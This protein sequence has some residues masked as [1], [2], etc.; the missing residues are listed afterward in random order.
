M[1]NSGEL[2][3]LDHSRKKVN[4]LNTLLQN[5]GYTC[6]KALYADAASCVLPLDPPAST[7]SSADNPKQAPSVAAS[8]NQEVE[9]GSKHAVD[10]STQKKKSNVET[11][12]VDVGTAKRVDRKAR[13]AAARAKGKIDK[14]SAMKLATATAAASSEPSKSAAYDKSAKC[15]GFD[16]E[17][18]DSVL[19][20]PP[21]SA[22]GL[23]PRLRVDLSVSDVEE[24]VAAQRRIFWA[25]VM[26][27]K[28]GGCLVF[29][30]C[31]VGVRPFCPACL[32]PYCFQDLI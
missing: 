30:T 11:P 12:G 24:M 15:L 27:L 16:A 8:A 31:T 10:S 20:D 23:R 26:L 19:L 6:A 17:S 5:L 25:A 7:T 32:F 14:H 18:F 29:S 28:P 13:V 4:E 2:Y 3:A 22:L 1:L 9:T 21:C